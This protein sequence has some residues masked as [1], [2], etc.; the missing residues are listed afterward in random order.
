M[1]MKCLQK[2]PDERYIDAESLEKDFRSLRERMD[3][4]VLHAGKDA[5]TGFLIGAIVLFF[6]MAAKLTF[7]TA[8][9]IILAAIGIRLICLA[10]TMIF[11]KRSVAKATP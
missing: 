4:E 10:V 6:I 1:I 3:S 11:R 7:V 2:N 8:S 5:W 9:L